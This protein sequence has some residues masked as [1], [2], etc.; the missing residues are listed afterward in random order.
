[1]DQLSVHERPTGGGTRLRLFTALAIPNDTTGVLADYAEAMAGRVEGARA[2]AKEGMHTTWAFLGNV[3]EEYVPAVAR[4]LDVAAGSVPGPTLC[5]VAGIAPFGRNRALGVEVDVELLALLDSA[6]D[7]FL[8]AV[9]AYAPDADRR[10]WR[11][12]V[13]ILRAR[14]GAALPNALIEA[15]PAPPA[16]SWVVPELRLYASLPGPAGHQHKVLHA[17]PFGAPVVQG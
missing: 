9:I 8:E 7:R 10:A 12:H 17:V 15:P 11:P 1:M 5:T 4:A 16:V 14:H 6:R 3:A 2:V 13:T